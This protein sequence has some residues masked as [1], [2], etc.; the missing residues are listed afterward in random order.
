MIV[1]AIIYASKTSWRVKKKYTQNIQPVISCHQNKAKYM[2]L[3]LNDSGKLQ[4]SFPEIPV[5]ALETCIYFIYITRI[6]LKIVNGRI[7]NNSR[8][9]AYVQRRQRQ[10]EWRMTDEKSRKCRSKVSFF[11]FKW[12]HNYFWAAMFIHVLQCSDFC[13]PSHPGL[14]AALVCQV[15]RGQ[16]IYLFSCHLSC[17]FLFLCPVHQTLDDGELTECWKTR[18]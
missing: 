2:S 7:W 5:K 12:L 9:S 1:R 13:V 10:F 11:F 3:F 14:K 4:G 15:Y 8:K 16:R 18:N 6:P 17:P